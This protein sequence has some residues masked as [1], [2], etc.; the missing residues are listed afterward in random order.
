M[1]PP[2]LPTSLPTPTLPTPLSTLPVSS[3]VEHSL[4]LLG[5]LLVRLSTRFLAVVGRRGRL[6]RHF[7][8]L[9]TLELH[10][11]D[12]PTLELHTLVRLMP[13][14]LTQVKLIKVLLILEPLLIDFCT[15]KKGNIKRINFMIFVSKK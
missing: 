12:L 2:R 1:S 11:L 3:L 10:T 8:V 15:Q 6:N 7:L 5:T 4:V 13:A 9:H 14:L